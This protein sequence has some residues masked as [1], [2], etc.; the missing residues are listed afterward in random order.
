M[1]RTVYF[2]KI[3][4]WQKLLLLT[5]IIIFSSIIAGLSGLLIGKLF[6][7]VDFA[8]LATY[9]SNPQT[10][11]EVAFLKFYQFINQIG[12]FILPV[13]L[14]SFVVSPSA[15]KYLYL[16]NK[17]NITNL[18]VMGI[19]VFTVLPF[20]NYLGEINQQMSFPDSLSWL[21]DWMK[22][23][24]EQVM[25]V[26][27]VFLK[28]TSVWVL[29][30][31]IFIVALIPAIGEEILFRGVLLRLFN[32]ISRNIHVAVFMSSLL[33]A[34]I[35]MQFYGFLPRM[36]LGMILGYSLVITRNL[37]VAIFIHFINNTA[38]VIVY[39]LHYNG[40]LKIPME[41]FGKTQNI[42][43]ITGSLL[44]TIWLMIIVYQREG[45]GFKRW[46]I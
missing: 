21:E 28:T 17:P 39:F 5:G 42:A 38:S 6:F 34:A 1:K 15:K 2:E 3:S 14:F 31:N 9:I 18:L 23:K 46:E 26:T 35:H 16:Q 44:I 10:R 7:D 24:E 29:L 12:V 40:Y 37:W 41:D 25:M 8:T 45:P 4:P 36:F 32:E 22:Q 13:M 30:V 19:V 43:Y 27:E 20:I 33:F 11:Q